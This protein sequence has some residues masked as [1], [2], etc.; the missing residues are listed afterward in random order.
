[1]GL[2]VEGAGRAI[3]WAATQG[4]L[5]VLQATQAAPPFQVAKQVEMEALLRLWAPPLSSN[6]GVDTGDGVWGLHF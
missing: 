5:V 4:A 2:I 6:L 1:L 3:T